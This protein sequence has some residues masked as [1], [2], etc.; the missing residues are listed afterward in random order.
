MNKKPKIL[1]AISE[2][3]KEVSKNRN[4]KFKKDVNKSLPIN[5]VTNIRGG[6]RL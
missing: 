3:K 1:N 4:R 6:I 5:Y 2:A